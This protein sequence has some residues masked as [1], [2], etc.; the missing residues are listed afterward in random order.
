M[1]S[2]TNQFLQYLP[3]IIPIIL[4]QLVL[5]IIALVD[6]SRRE[7]VRGLPKWA[8]AIIII[9]GELVGPIVYLVIGRVD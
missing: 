1:E 8:W 6:L 5:M 3:Y 9:F 2:A 7:K 4:L